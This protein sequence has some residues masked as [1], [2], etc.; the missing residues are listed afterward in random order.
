MAAKRW[1][2][3]EVVAERRRV[4]GRDF[5]P[6]REDAER[7][8]RR[9]I[10]TRIGHM[11]AEEIVQ[12]GRVFNRHGK[13]GQV[14]QDRFSPGFA[15]A[16]MAKLAQNTERFNE[17][18]S[19]LWRGHLDDAVYLLGQMF[20]DRSIL[21]GAGS[22]LPSYLLY[23][24]E[25]ERFGIC[26]NATMTGLGV[27]VGE[28][29]RANNQ[30]SYERFCA[31]L[32]EWRRKYGVA[33]QEADA[34]LTEIMRRSRPE[35]APEPVDPA[36]ERPTTDDVAA[37]CHLP[38]EQVDAWVEALE[39]GMR[40]A[41]FFGPPG[42]GKTHVARHLARHL[43]TSPGNV[44]ITQFHPAYSYED[45]V[46]GLRPEGGAGGTLHYAVRKGVFSKLCAGASKAPKETFVLVIDE[47]NRADLAAVFGELL[48]LLEYR[49]TVSA[50][51]PYSQERFRVP[52]NVIVLGTMNTA[53]RSLA[54][55]DFALRRRFHAFP[56]LP[57]D[58]VIS[59]WAESR[60]AVDADLA[61]DVFRLIRDRI[62]HDSPI[63]PGH[64][65][66]MV[67]GIDARA[68][69]RIWEYQLR[70]YLA[71]YWFERPTELN[72]LDADVRALIAER[73]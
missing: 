58:D 15:G 12:L 1:D 73:A 56:L 39:K 41:V 26:L 48:L 50:T 28:R 42:T 65:Y 2:T 5:V 6:S 10:D 53:D 45:F 40:Q 35:D 55:L 23:L 3:H 43:A 44:E 70:P 14:R 46:E 11:N 29:F 9:I 62:G 8:A 64:S 24:R 52:R 20:A 66:W 21:P 49:D 47:M 33:P 68:A 16:V 59:K 34:I 57:S 71:E 37:A 4:F 7:E 30:E 60:K 27:E 69:Q 25:P 32:V 63:S 72:Q 18:V 19:R 31:A 36:E 54:L 17:V 22:S 51:L 38:V 67:E 61:L 13:T